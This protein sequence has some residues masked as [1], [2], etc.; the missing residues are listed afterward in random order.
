[1]RMNPKICLEKMDFKMRGKMSV[2]K[3]KHEHKDRNF[4]NMNTNSP[5]YDFLEMTYCT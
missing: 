2:L 4:S 5:F 3:T 1:M